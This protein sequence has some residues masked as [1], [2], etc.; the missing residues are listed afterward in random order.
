MML[1]DREIVFAPI[2]KKILESILKKGKQI[3][4]SGTFDPIEPTS[5]EWSL[6]FDLFKIGKIYDFRDQVS[7]EKFKAKCIE[8]TDENLKFKW[9]KKI[10]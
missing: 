2:D 10:K 9:V 4:F 1:G 5:R 3:K 7:G 8:K 6:V